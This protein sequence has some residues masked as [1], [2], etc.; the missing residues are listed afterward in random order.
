MRV[1]YPIAMTDA[2]L[3]SSNVTENDHATWASGTTYAAEDRVIVVSTHS[4]YESVQGSN[5]GNDPT[6]DDGTWWVRVGATNRWKA[7]DGY[8]AD[9][10]ERS[11]T[12]T[13]T[14]TPSGVVTGIAFFGL[15]AT[16]VR[17]QVSAT[18]YDR[19]IDLVDGTEVT[20]WLDF[21]T[22]PIE[23]DTEALFADVAS[24]TDQIVITI[25]AGAGT[26]KVGQIV[27]GRVVQLGEVV[28]GTQP[29]FVSFAT[30]SRDAF[31]R[32]LLVD[33]DFADTVRFRFHAP[34]QKQRLIK[35]T[36]TELDTT[37][38]VWFAQE[39]MEAFG[40]QI[41]GYPVDYDAP[42]S[43]GGTTFYNLEIEG[44]T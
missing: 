20:D 43:S 18:G 21:F 28:D 14:F 12:I 30:K 27:F 39:G 2:Q 24:Y 41:Y 40:L 7:F 17:V 29:D 35:R 32:A 4:V 5:T 31:G 23:Y 26:A 6:T 10:V 25:D 16:S 15:A 8:I 9:Q 36:V 34:T 11:G 22:Q 38:A 37:P 42:L 19:T 33:R 3:D 44:L 1:I 13:Y